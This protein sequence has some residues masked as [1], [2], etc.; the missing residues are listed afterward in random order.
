MGQ[1]VLIRCKQV[2]KDKLL[3]IKTRTLIKRWHN[4]EKWLEVTIYLICL[5]KPVIN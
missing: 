2:T 1:Q 3:K 4:E 5:D